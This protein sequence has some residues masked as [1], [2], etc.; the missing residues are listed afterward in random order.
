MFASHD[1][2]ESFQLILSRTGI[3]F[4]ALELVGDDIYALQPGNLSVGSDRGAE[5]ESWGDPMPPAIEYDLA[6]WAGDPGAVY[7]SS[8]GAGVYAMDG[9]DGFHRAGIPA[10]QVLALASAAGPDGETLIAGTPRDTFH[11]TPPGR[12]SIVPADLEWHSAGGEGI[13]GAA[14]LFL[15]TSPTDP[16]VVYKLRTDAVLTFGI[17]RSDDGGATWQR[18]SSPSERPFGLLVHPADADTVYASHGSLTGAG[19]VVTRDGGGTWE[20]L[21]QGRIFQALAG[22]PTDPDRLWAGD[23]QGLYLSEDGG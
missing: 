7:V 12:E 2:G 18:L 14:A 21:D 17:W 5:W 4:E 16:S 20:K 8:H 10:T 19:L 9:S 23:H 11:T 22:D 13:S 6:Q 15:A 1:G 3:G